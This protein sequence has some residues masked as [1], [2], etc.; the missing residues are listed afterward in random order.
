MAEK[1]PFVMGAVVGVGGLLL[2][3][4][5][6]AIVAL[7][8]KMR[9]P[10]SGLGHM[11]AQVAGNPAVA[12]RHLKR[13]TFAALQDQSP[14]VGL[15]HASY[16]MMA[17]DLLEEVA[18]RDAI[19][20]QGYDAAEIRELVTALQDKHAERLKSCDQYIQKV[21]GLHGAGM[22]DMGAAPTGA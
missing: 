9:H 11:R 16:A 6:H 22:L 3:W 2:W 19:K 17:L 15:T 14:I 10:L 13:Y 18:G 1:H 12:I 5:R 8:H 4:K 20:A 21:L 7:F